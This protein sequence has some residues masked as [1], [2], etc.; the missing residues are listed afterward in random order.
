[1]R[2]MLRFEPATQRTT[3]PA[4][5]GLSLLPGVRLTP[6]LTTLR[7][8]AVCSRSA[9]MCLLSTMQTCSASARH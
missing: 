8:V 7:I 4:T 3:R 1:M 5:E 2:R 6:P 9:S